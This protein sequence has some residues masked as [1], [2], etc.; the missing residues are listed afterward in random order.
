MRYGYSFKGTEHYDEG[1]AQKRRQRCDPKVPGSNDD[2]E[3]GRKPYHGRRREAVRF[4][5]HANN[6]T[7]AEK[8]HTGDN[9]CGDTHQNI[10][11]SG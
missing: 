7:R 5:T 11:P 4:A 6:G 10:H 2:A 9:P 8:T 1:D 3:S